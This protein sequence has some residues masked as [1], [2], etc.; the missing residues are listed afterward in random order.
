MVEVER[1]EEILDSKSYFGQ[2]GDLVLL[3]TDDRLLRLISS[4]YIHQRS[5]C[6]M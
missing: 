4:E 6:K 5:A 1:K 3:G 2:G